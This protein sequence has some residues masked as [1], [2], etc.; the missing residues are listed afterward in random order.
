MNMDVHT[1]CMNDLGV[2]TAH[3]ISISQK[4]GERFENPINILTIVKI[5]YISFAK[6]GKECWILGLSSL[7][8]CDL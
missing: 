3:C 1:T 4:D 5:W 8:I 7:H 6:K 2:M